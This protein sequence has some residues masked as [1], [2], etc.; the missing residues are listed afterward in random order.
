M[1]TYEK[2]VIVVIRFVAILW[3]LYSLVT[4]ASMALAG[5]GQFGIRLTPVFLIS[6]LVPLALYFAARLLARI[7]TAGI[8]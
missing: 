8:D 1:S 2:V 3:F 6:L 4:F 7:I 5:F